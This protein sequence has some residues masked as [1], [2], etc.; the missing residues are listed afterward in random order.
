MNTYRVYVTGTPIGTNR[1]VKDAFN[2]RSES[3]KKI[4]DMLKVL[5]AGIPLTAKGYR[6]LTWHVRFIHKVND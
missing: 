4:R 1:E 5:P 6:C 3:P 2:I